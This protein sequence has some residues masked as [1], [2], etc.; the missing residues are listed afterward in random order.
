[1]NFNQKGQSALEYL[2]TYGWALVVIVI[3]VA[4]L[5]VLINPSTI[6]GNTCDAKLGNLIISQ[7][8]IQAGTTEFVLV[9]QSDAA[10]DT[11]SF[12]ISGTNGGTIAYVPVSATPDITSL[13]ANQTAKVTITQVPGFISPG[14]YAL[15]YALSYN[16][17][18]L[19]GLSA[20]AQCR[21]SLP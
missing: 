14:A 10:V 5:V 3:A 11:M 6:Q 1:M 4:A 16:A 18:N 7:S 9:N 17:G 12:T 20:S 21:G 2:M 8:N 15:T 13:A 19:T